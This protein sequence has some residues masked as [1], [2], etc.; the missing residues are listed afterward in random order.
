MQTH[1]IRL[2]A[3][4]EAA[5]AAKRAAD[6]LGAGGLVVFPTETVYG[7]AASAAH[8]A[9]LERLWG[10][11]QLAH[12]PPFTLHVGKREQ[13]ERFVPRTSTVARRMMQ[14][15][16]PGPLTLV[17]SVPDPAA[18][19]AFAALSPVSQAALYG[20]QSL[21]ARLPDHP[22]AERL[23]VACA[24]PCVATSANAPGREAPVALD[25]I[26]RELLEQVDLALDTGRTR[27]ARASTVV[28]LNG[29]GYR[30]TRT[31][32][33][34]ERTVRL[35]ATYTLLFVC[36]GNTCRSPMAAG[37]ARQALARRLG[38]APDE[39]AD[40]GVTVASAGTM[41]MG[42]MPAASEAV[43]VLEAR[44]ADIRDHRSAPLSAD[45]VMR[46]DC[47]FTMTAAH[48]SAVLEQSPE[49]RERLNRLDASGDIAD[50]LG[51]SQAEYEACA[52][53]IAAA[54]ESRLKE[55]PL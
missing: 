53:R 35:L 52:A 54:L 49:A 42:G 26:P 15:G 22:L 12:R 5:A 18:A 51:G 10:L 16:W 13:V 27:Y 45:L 38:C 1:R 32:V 28:T 25:D 2:D 39:L 4:D 17:F 34:D 43:A 40:R 36:S 14:K 20:Q 30:V 8:P 55:L 31:G 23:F 47:I 24:A 19:A 11:K 48:E 33:L 3:A 50:P 6:V 46:A 7:I 29:D 37:L 9:A 21:A 41:C 44:G